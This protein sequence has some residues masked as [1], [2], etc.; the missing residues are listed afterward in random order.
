MIV[1]VTP[2]RE[3]ICRSLVS[4]EWDWNGITI[5]DDNRGN[6]WTTSRWQ[7]FTTTTVERPEH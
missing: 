7:G 3:A 1:S 4:H 5:G 2:A 6:R